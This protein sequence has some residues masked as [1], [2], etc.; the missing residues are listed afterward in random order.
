M[1][2]QRHWNE[3]LLQHFIQ[4]I[5]QHTGLHVREQDWSALCQKIEF[6]CQ[7]L[8]LPEPQ[9]YYQ[10]LSA[11]TDAS[12][13]EWQELVVVLT[14]GESYFFRDRGQ[15]FLLRNRLLPELIERQ[16]QARS[17]KVWSAGCSTGEEAYS[18]AILLTELIP[19]WPEW[20]LLILGTD[21]N[22]TALDRA[23]L[24]SYSSW[25]FRLVSPEIQNRYFFPVRQNWK[26]DDRIGHLVTFRYG[27]LMETRL[28]NIS[29]NPQTVD[30]IL[31]R[32]VLVYFEPFAISTALQNFY[33][34][35]KPGGYLMTGHAEVP[36]QSCRQVQSL[37]FPQSVVYQRLPDL[38]TFSLPKNTVKTAKSVLDLEQI[39]RATRLENLDLSSNLT[40]ANRCQNPLEKL[41][42]SPQK[43]SPHAIHDNSKL[44]VLFR[45][46]ETLFRN[47]S[48]PE[49]IQKASQL[50]DLQ[51]RHFDAYYLIARVYANLGQ[52]TQAAHY[53]QL[54]LA[55]DSLSI[56][57]HY[58]LATIAEEKGDIDVAKLFLKKIIYLEPTAVCAY[59]ELGLLYAK[60]ANIKTAKK[61]WAIALELLKKMPEDTA[62]EC[63]ASLT[64][65]ELLCRVKK[66]L[67]TFPSKTSGD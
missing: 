65:K 64:A 12:Q 42:D 59:L 31:C 62:I 46:A 44:T 48:Y 36:H 47:Q 18:L 39:N 67:S 33:K 7:L 4:L 26:L 3:T 37:V 10:L 25:S 35:L 8:K 15:M 24:G 6:R 17:L 63:P 60:E 34:F 61:K 32:N 13:Y 55:V 41:T 14:N 57:P 16:R 22:C 51:P 29:I 1:R 43:E 21:I 45:Q 20:D 66:L 9:A 38:I 54:A 2:S 56:P 19:D 53:S 40:P 58:L 27:N 23:R 50:I 11:N 28:D 30:L 49:A 52:L 5:S